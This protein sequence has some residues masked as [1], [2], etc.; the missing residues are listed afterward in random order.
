MRWACLPPEKAPH[1]VCG[2]FLF[3]YPFRHHR[4]HTKQGRLQPH[5]ATKSRNP[6]QPKAK[7]INA[8]Q[9]QS[10]DVFP[11]SAH[12]RAYEV[13]I[14]GQ[15]QLPVSAT[16]CAHITHKAFRHTNRRYIKNPSRCFVPRPHTARKKCKPRLYRKSPECKLR[17]YSRNNYGYCA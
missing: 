5:T 2:A 7:L 10:C 6:Y 15:L 3:P 14:S 9:N 1:G 17:L 11:Y 12:I 16:V 8:P 4:P 13:S